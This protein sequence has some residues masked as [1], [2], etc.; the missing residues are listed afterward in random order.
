MYLR[1]I[2]CQKEYQPEPHRYVC[3]TCDNLH[4]TLEVVYDYDQIHL[5]RNFSKHGSI[6]QFEKLLPTTSH[7]VVDALVGGTPLL[8]FENKL[9]RKQLL[10]KNDGMS[11]SG[12]YKDRASII[13]I[14]RAIEEKNE[15]IFCASTGNAASSLALLNAHTHM[16]TSIFVP[17]KIPK[18][19][20]AQLM[21]AGADVKLIDASYDE[22]FDLSLAIG[23]KNNWYTRH[24]AINPYLLEG[25]KTG[26]FEIIVQNDYIVP[27]YCFVAVGDGTIISGICK[28]FEEFH[29]LKLIDRLPIIIGVQAKGSNTL[30][31][32]FDQG[33]PFEPMDEIVST[34]ADSISVGN[35]RDVIKACTYLSRVGGRMIDVS[36]EAILNSIVLLASETGVFSEPAGAAAVAGYLSIQNEIPEDQSVCLIITGNGLKDTDAISDLKKP[37][38]YTKEEIQAFYKEGRNES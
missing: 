4:G 29:K 16:K 19:K 12:S 2:T 38:I 15:H 33:P 9:N 25:K 27:D 8:K 26:A 20:L 1:C 17:K 14:N 13:A 37:E 5:E 10:I 31:K 28:G 32:V 36:D 24:S 3:D 11:F 6:F 23:L 30:K 35:P 22:V 7:T 18:G 34:V 21:A